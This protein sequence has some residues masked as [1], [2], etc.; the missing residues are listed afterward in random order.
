MWSS[1]FDALLQNPGEFLPGNRLHHYASHLLLDGVA[2]FEQY[3][4]TEFSEENLQ[5]WQACKRYQTSNVNNSSLSV[6]V[7]ARAIYN[8]FLVQ[9]APKQVSSYTDMSFQLHDS[10]NFNIHPILH[11]CGA[12]GVFIRLKALFGY[13][14]FLING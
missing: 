14:H 10:L 13:P 9:G 11:T 3:L 6:L 7:E 2:L 4:V 12:W 1:S 8:E 5:F